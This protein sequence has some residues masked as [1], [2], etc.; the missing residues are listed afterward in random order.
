MAGQHLTARD[1]G[2]GHGLRIH[3]NYPNANDWKQLLERIADD[4]ERR[5][6][7]EY[8]VGIYRR[9]QAS[10]ATLARLETR[11]RIQEFGI[12]G[13]GREG[14]EEAEKAIQATGVAAPADPGEMGE[15]GPAA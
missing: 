9:I 11:E 15:P 3:R 1:R 7:R 2:L 12:G 13:L 8:L 6:A 10:A 4:E 5:I 14:W